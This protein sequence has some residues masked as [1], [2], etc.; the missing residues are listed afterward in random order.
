VPQG[1]ADVLALGRAVQPLD[2]PERLSHHTRRAGR[3]EQGE[4]LVAEDNSQD[5][6]HIRFSY[7]ISKNEEEFR[8]LALALSP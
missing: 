3:Q 2:H 8:V 7:A 1:G 6:G 4:S 5:A